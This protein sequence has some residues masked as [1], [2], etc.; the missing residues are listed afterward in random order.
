MNSWN[1][2]RTTP[3]PT[4]VTA[5]AG[6]V[7]RSTAPVS[8]PLRRWTCESSDPGMV[9]QT[10]MSSRR[11]DFGMCTAA[12]LAPAL[13]RWISV[14]ATTG[15]GYST[16]LQ[17]L[18]RQ[19]ARQLPERAQPFVEGCFR[20]FQVLFR[21]VSGSMSLPTLARICAEGSC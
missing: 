9:R 16:I 14:T 10:S 7:R 6:N 21:F 19:R 20:P 13:D 8:R 15:Q 11:T 2:Y 1:T 3:N 4:I 5:I 18:L 17:S 12:C